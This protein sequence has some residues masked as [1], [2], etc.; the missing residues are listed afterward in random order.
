[1]RI[2]TRMFMLFQDDVFTHLYTLIVKPDNTYIV[3]IDNEKVESGDLES[4]WDFLPTKKIKV[5]CFFV[6]LSRIDALLRQ[7]RQ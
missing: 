1:M 4:D 3:K 2:E 5:Y 7:N 6:F